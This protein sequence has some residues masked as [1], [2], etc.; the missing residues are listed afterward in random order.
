MWRHTHT[1][2]RTDGLLTEIVMELGWER[3]DV[4]NKSKMIQL[5]NNESR[6]RT[7]LTPPTVHPNESTDLGWRDT[8][9]RLLGDSHGN[10]PSPETSLPDQLPHQALP[11]ILKAKRRDDTAVRHDFKLKLRIKPASNNRHRMSVTTRST[12]ETHN[13]HHQK[14]FSCLM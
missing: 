9:S 3:A 11:F 12:A 10:R 1:Q 4:L 2:R 6:P 5:I 14:R 13:V 8:N 7:P